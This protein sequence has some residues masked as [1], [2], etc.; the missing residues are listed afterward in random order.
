MQ[1][2][3]PFVMGDVPC[4]LYETGTKGEIGEEWCDLVDRL[5]GEESCWVLACASKILACEASILSTRSIL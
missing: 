5:D 1:V 2:P 4:P 3:V